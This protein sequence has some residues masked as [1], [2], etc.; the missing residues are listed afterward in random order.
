MAIPGQWEPGS[1]VTA[2]SLTPG[3]LIFSRGCCVS[4][5]LLDVFSVHLGGTRSRRL[6]ALG[7]GG[8]VLPLTLKQILEPLVP[9][10]SWIQ[11]RRG[12]DDPSPAKP[13]R[14]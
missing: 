9:G 3:G 7:A 10:L 14:S 1:Y 12:D 11:G 4:A 2:S 8:G 13:R 5:A 6:E